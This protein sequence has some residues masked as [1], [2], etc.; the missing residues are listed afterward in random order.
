MRPCLRR[1]GKEGERERGEGGEGEEGEEEVE[2]EEEGEGFPVIKG[3]KICLCSFL[4]QP[5][6]LG[7][8]GSLRIKTWAQNREFCS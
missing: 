7:S 8:C 2:K 3:A 5:S 4:R 6:S 1:W